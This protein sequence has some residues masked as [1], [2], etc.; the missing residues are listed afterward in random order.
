VDGP[1]EVAVVARQHQ[2]VA[3]G[4][5]LE[6]ELAVADGGRGVEL[7]GVQLERRLVAQDLLGHDRDGAVVEQERREPGVRLHGDRVAVGAHVLDVADAVR[8]RVAQQ[9]VVLLVVVELKR[10]HDVVRGDG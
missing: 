3:L 1:A 7:V 6:L 9:A 5:G 4:P 2:L 10:E 8:A